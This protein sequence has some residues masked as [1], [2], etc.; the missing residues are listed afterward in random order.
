MFTGSGHNKGFPIAVDFASG[1]VA[2]GPIRNEGKDSAAILYADGRIYFCDE[3]GKTAVIEPGKEFR[4]LAENQLE[5]QIMASPAIAGRAI[6]LRTDT[7]LYRL[8]EK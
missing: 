7:H 3:E 2:W 4:A 1:K 5:G 6:F 8:E